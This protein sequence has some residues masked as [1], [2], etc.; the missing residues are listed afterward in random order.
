[1]VAISSS[2]PAS[3]IVN[4]S[5]FFMNSRGSVISLQSWSIIVHV[6]FFVDPERHPLKHK[7]VSVGHSLLA[8]PLEE[9]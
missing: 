2:G 1:V 5:S 9:Y 7:N 3:G 8:L 4:G 6:I